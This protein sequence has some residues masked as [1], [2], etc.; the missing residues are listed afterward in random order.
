MITPKKNI[1]EVA[2]TA[3]SFQLSGLA[4]NCQ[5]THIILC[6]HGWL[7][8]A[9]SFTPILQYFESQP[10]FNHKII[11]IDL[12]GHGASTHKSID[13]HYHFVDWV[14][15]VLSL[16]ESNQWGSV[17]LVGHSM[18]GMVASAF[19]AAFPE[20]VKSLT[21]LDSAGFMYSNEQESTQVLREGL[22]SRIKANK[23]ASRSSL[24]YKNKQLS[25]DL[26]TKA[27]VFVSDLS[28]HHAKLIMA[29]NLLFSDNQWHWRSDRK[30]NTVSPYRFSFSQCQKIVSDIKVPVQIIYGSKS[31]YFVKNGIKCFA[32]LMPCKKIVELE[33]GHHVHMEKPAETAKLINAFISLY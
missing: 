32:P 16:F 11:A 24:S 14:Y 20:K 15:D 2:L 33:G 5:S 30:L 19:S 8:N 28:Y 7:D 22:L 26:V 6:L 25:L 1:K 31:V 17:H 18:G 27:R 21:L 9:A 12:P 4:L 23:N 13:A 29:R 10:Y 3:A